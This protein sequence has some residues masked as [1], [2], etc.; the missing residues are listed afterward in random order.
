L[1]AG[2]RRAT[3]GPMSLR[4]ATLTVDA[5]DPAALATWWQQVLGGE[6]DGSD[7][8][9]EVVLDVAGAAPILFN[10]ERTPKTVK[11]RLHFDLR[12]DDRD[13]EVERLLR[14]GAVRVDIGQA[15]DPGTTWVVLAD[16]EGN[17]FCVLRGH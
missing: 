5:R 8:P 12:P 17:E 2:S 10:M 14:L 11:N 15:A 6:V 3:L 1:G 16:P 9:D 7:A 4:L 13:A